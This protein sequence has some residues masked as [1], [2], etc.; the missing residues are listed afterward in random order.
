MNTYY[1]AGLPFSDQNALSH[2]RTFGSK[3]G[4][5]HTPGYIAK[6]KR[7]KGP[8]IVSDSGTGMVRKT[9]SQG[10]D[11][12]GSM[13]NTSAKRGKKKSGGKNRHKGEGH[14]YETD[15]HGNEI[16]YG[17]T[18][19]SRGGIKRASEKIKKFKK[20]Q[21]A[22]GTA[23]AS[24]SASSMDQGGRRL[25]GGRTG[26]RMDARYAELWRRLS[27]RGMSATQKEK[28]RLTREAQAYSQR[29]N[30]HKTMSSVEK[31]VRI[32]GQKVSEFVS[33]HGKTAVTAIKETARKVKS[34]LSGI[35][36]KKKK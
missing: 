22:V 15:S 31:N 10:A 29:I 25:H 26:F 23:F 7:A 2:G 1:V 20:K 32:V 19:T 16:H 17:S 33:K 30:P 4:I 35:F 34:F 36:G 18:T 12:A 24:E 14:T 6:G 5:S 21:S 28:D 13:V 8:Q 3:N 27:N 11:F 9:Y